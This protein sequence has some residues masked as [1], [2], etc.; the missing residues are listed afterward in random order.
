MLGLSFALAVQAMAEP[1]AERPF[2][3]R[4]QAPPE[5]PTAAEVRAAIERHLAAPL[6]SPRGDGLRVDASARVEGDGRW[7]V[8]LVV[9][10]GEGRSER[11]IGDADDCAAATETAA[12]V[13]AIAIDPDVALREPP[14]TVPAPV[15]PTP[16]E[17]TPVEPT[18]TKPTTV[19]PPPKPAPP[20]PAPRLGLRAAIGGRFDVMAGAHPVVGLGGSVFADLIL[21][22]RGRIGIGA[23]LSGAPPQRQSGATIEMLR[24]TIEVRGCPVFGV[25]RWLEIVPCA[26]VQA[27]QTRVAVTGLA[28][29]TSPRHPWLAP[30]ALVAAVFV[31]RPR[32]GIWLGVHGVVPIYR[33][34]YVI[35][36]GGRVHRTAPVAGGALIG[37]EAR[38]P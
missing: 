8:A 30:T 13:V 34:D 38:L 36:G 22:G 28:D 31:P 21:G 6:E 11:E 18:P 27:G 1:P 24:W 29:A 23:S 32:I 7:G 35:A 33:H 15:E 5:C 2:E 14:A 20:K 26:G 16:V 9:D 4:W 12:L 3:L 10:S 19:T 37:I 25:R 17:P